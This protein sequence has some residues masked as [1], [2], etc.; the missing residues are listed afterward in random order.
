MFNK[1]ADW[2]IIIAALAAVTVSFWAVYLGISG[3]S[4]VYLKS[5][6]GSWVYPINAIDT[7]K[8]SGP[9]GDTFVEIADGRAYISSSPCLNKTCVT[10]GYI[11]QS[12]QWAAC[13][14][15]KVLLYISKSEDND[16]VD[17]TTW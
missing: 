13:L 14:P 12:G 16:D 8:I 1:T 9:L 4:S 3:N 15:N 6:G 10:T 11:H 17:A 7:I 2:V 5:D